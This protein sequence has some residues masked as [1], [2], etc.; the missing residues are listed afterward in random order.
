MYEK[1]KDYF[2]RMVYTHTYTI[3]YEYLI[4]FS[5][6][7]FFIKNINKTLNYAKFYFFSRTSIFFI[8]NIKIRLTF[9]YL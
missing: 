5:F 2:H 6:Y 9:I 3:C 4:F 8:F 7:V 1:Q